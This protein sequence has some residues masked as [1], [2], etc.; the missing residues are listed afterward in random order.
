MEI[1]FIE[2]SKLWSSCFK[3]NPQKLQ[4]VARH[5]GQWT[6]P[7]NWGPLFGL[8]SLPRGPH[9]LKLQK[10]VPICSQAEDSVCSF[11][12]CWHETDTCLNSSL[13]VLQSPSSF[14]SLSV[15]PL[16]FHHLLGPHL[17]LF[18]PCQV[19]FRRLFLGNRPAISNSPAFTI[20]KLVLPTHSLLPS[21]KAASSVALS[22]NPACLKVSKWLHVHTPTLITV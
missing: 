13:S 5:E 7:P 11:I 1:S 12:G 8:N 21:L 10:K 16:L 4:I 15:V 9:S 17:C 6:P 2:C 18:Y 14:T 22:L 19:L 3:A 20:I